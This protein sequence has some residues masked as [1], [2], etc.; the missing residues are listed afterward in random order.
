MANNKLNI[1]CGG[2]I[3]I[4]IALMGVIAALVY[5][6]NHMDTITNF[7]V[8]TIILVLILIIWVKST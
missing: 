1:G 8:G 7:I 6:S 4:L 2:A 5:A 3:A